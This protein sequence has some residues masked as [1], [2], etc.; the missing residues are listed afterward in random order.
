MKG[1]GDQVESGQAGGRRLD[2]GE[3]KEGR[4]KWPEGISVVEER[5]DRRQRVGGRSSDG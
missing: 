1:T 4:D 5:A 2:H 3:A